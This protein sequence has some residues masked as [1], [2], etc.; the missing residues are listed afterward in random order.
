MLDVPEDE[1]FSAY[2]DGELTG[3]ELAEMEHVLKTSPAARKIL[4]ELRVLSDTLQSLPVV[5]LEEDLSGR[6]LRAAERRILSE[7][8][9]TDR[10]RNTWGSNPGPRP[11]LLRRLLRG[12]TLWWSAVAVAVAIFFAFGD[13]SNRAR[14]PGGNN[15]D[16][17]AMDT[18]ISA[19]PGDKV[20][21]V[22]AAE[23]SHL[24]PVM[25]ADS[26]PVGRMVEVPAMEDHSPVEQAND[27]QTLV[28]DSGKPAAPESVPTPDDSSE[29][30]KP[31]DGV[32][33]VK[34]DVSE[35]GA[36]GQIL[37]EILAKRKIAR[38]NGTDTETGRMFVEVDLT[39]TQLRALVA[40]LRSRRE[41]FVAV[42]VPPSPGAA[43]PRIPSAA[44]SSQKA[45][46]TVKVTPA[47]S[48]QVGQAEATV[49]K[50]EPGTEKP[51]SKP[52]GVKRPSR[53]ERKFRVRFELNV[54]A[55]ATGEPS[56]PS[57]P[58]DASSKGKE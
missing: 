28:A 50:A 51:V 34:C 39:P 29:V 16:D 53:E 54:V 55:P 32:L 33:I 31:G 17:Q 42:S 6:V 48:G 49:P 8:L 22:R 56:A 3:E 5:E 43:R 52:D 46:P 24:S 10:T 30:T 4:G 44:G 19:D 11:R 27:P 35:E 41:N 9:E 45:T 2:L 15:Q 23:D 21:E 12:R 20:L 1:L 57:R 47:A 7:P 18:A 26:P 13:L 38:L 40:D 37:G 58:T 14:R 25:E 36:D